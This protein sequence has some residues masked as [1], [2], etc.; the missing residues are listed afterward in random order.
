MNKKILSIKKYV[1]QSMSSTKGCVATSV[2]LEISDEEIEDLKK[3][4][5]Q[6]RRMMIG[7]VY[8]E[9]ES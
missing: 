6:V 9:K 7:Y 4:Y 2:P 8:F 5:K 1:D 3:Y